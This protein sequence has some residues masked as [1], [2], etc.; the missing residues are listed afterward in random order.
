MFLP[1]K[2]RPN[3]D[4][5]LLFSINSPTSYIE[6]VSPIKPEVKFT[7][8]EE[9]KFYWVL[10]STYMSQPRFI[11]VLSLLP[12]RSDNTCL[13]TKTFLLLNLNWLLR[14]K[15]PNLYCKK[16]TSSCTLEQAFQFLFSILWLE[17]SQQSNLQ[18]YLPPYEIHL[19]LSDFQVVTWN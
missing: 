7:Y 12:M 13:K 9:D 6:L 4:L 3:L 17:R 5:V 18:S 19:L 2:L 8:W 10:Q 16:L 15:E 11:R 14:E 1:L